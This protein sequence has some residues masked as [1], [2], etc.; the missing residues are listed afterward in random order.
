MRLRAALVASVLILSGCTTTPEINPIE[1]VVNGEVGLFEQQVIWSD[2]QEQ[3]ECADVATPLDG[4]QPDG[5]LI[6]IA[7]MRRT[8]TEGLPPLF[9]NPGGPGS[10]AITWMRDGYQSLGTSYLRQNFQVIAFDPRGVGQSTPVTCTDMG[11]KDRLL[12][13]ASP[14]SFGTEGDVEYFQDLAERFAESCQGEISTGYFNTQQT[15]RDLD[16]LRQLVNSEKLNY[17]GYSY[18]TE[19]GA[20][21]AA[22]FPKNL[23]LFVL[24]G[25]V[26]PTLD[27]ETSLLRQIEGFDKALNAYLEDCFSQVSC[28]LPSDLDEA[29]DTI[30][31]IL[32]GLEDRVM[33]TDYDRD[34]SLSAAIAGIIVTLY[35]QDSWPYLSSAIEDALAGDGSLLLMLADFYND[36][37]TEG[38]YLTNIVEA[39]SAI[40]C[41]DQLTYPEIE[42]DL[43][44]AITAASPVFGKYFAYGEGSCSGWPDGIGNQVLD[45]ELNPTS[46][47]LIV[48]TTGDPATPYEQA[49]SLNRMIA[50]SL[51]ITFEGEGHTAYG[52]N[53]C[54]N[55]LVDRYLAGES[56]VQGDLTCSQP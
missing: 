7:L 28:P 20:N 41:A 15:A 51:L 10:S 38:G 8:G 22:L 14:Y 33:P 27:P 19:L 31:S 53:P 23:G 35:S 13:G 52:S 39:N 45:F 16:L 26:D 55:D 5:Q 9:V 6:S 1:S 47:V 46:Q 4:N 21:Y 2:C 34:L 49:V 54:V 29:K 32:R 12:Y 3:F 44:S 17:L 25:A 48:G 43:T 18:G 56:L 24:D 50:G 42:Q 30:G 36:R 37:D 40:D 11:L